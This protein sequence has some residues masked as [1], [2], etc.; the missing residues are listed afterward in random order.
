MESLN[1][2]TKVIY[3]KSYRVYKERRILPSIKAG[4][5]AKTKDMGSNMLTLSQK[6]INYNV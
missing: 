5:T 2:K 3:I 1:G 4:T 6:I